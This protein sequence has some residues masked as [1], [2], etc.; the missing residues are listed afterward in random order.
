[1][2]KAVYPRFFN[3]EMSW[4]AFN[5]RVLE[6]GL[7]PKVP[8]LERLKFLAITASNLD[9]FCMVRVG[10]LKLLS[11][12]HVRCSDNTGLTPRQQLQRVVRRIRQ[13]MADQAALY[14]VLTAALE[15]H[16]LT[17]CE[18][19]SALSVEQRAWVLRE[20]EERVFPLLSPVALTLGRDYR[21]AGLLLHC[22][23]RL[24]ERH[25]EDE[26]CVA[27][28][29][30]GPNVPR[31]L[32]APGQSGAVFVP[33]ERVVAASAGRF[34]EGRKVLECV[35]FRVTRN[36][37]IELR[38]DLAPDLLVG[39]QE[40]LDERRETACVR[41]EIH[42]SASR[43]L[44]AYL[45]SYLGLDRTDLFPIDGP[46]DL[47]ALL[48]VVQAEGYETLRDESWR[49]V[50][51]PL[52][53]S[54]EPL[55]P[56]IA[57]RDIL[58]VHPYESFDPVVKFLEDAADDPDVMAIKQVLYR[59]ASGS[60]IVEALIRSAQAGKLVT[61][62]IELKARF[63][64][65]RNITQARRLEQAGVQVV[66]G[67]RGLKTHA[68]V[69]VV[70]RREP[71]GIVRYMHFGTGN[72]NERTATLYSDVGLFTCQ[73][74]LGADASDF[75]N[76]VTGYSQ[77][78]ALRRLEMSPFTLR[79]AL[80]QLISNE[81]AR[82]RNKEKALVM[83]KMNALTDEALIEALYAASKAGVKIRLNVRGICC[84]RPGVKGLSENISVVSIVDRFLE[85]ARIF[86]FLDGGQEK[87][88]IS[89][90]D[91]MLRNLDKRVEL[92]V[93]ILDLQAKR[94][95][96]KMLKIYFKDNVK[97]HMLCADGTYQRCRPAK[98]EPP[99]RSQRVLYEEAV[100]AVQ[101]VER[102][103]PTVLEPHRRRAAVK[104]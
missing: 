86:F 48:S 103:K 77:P 101:T 26:S 73:P 7:D 49:P 5:Q 21:P 33:V 4:L 14:R 55:F 82:A 54:K 22:A 85:H 63:D 19:M 12:G 68:K 16:G 58:L 29:P 79:T 41:L 37:D 31:Y 94:R 70:V 92:M 24:E 28:L 35:P 64:E 80:L 95:L 3:R 93:P 30:L 39:M 84:L 67:V 96:Q 45:A 89:S 6:E 57:E 47:R 102:M 42:R 36:A 75:F 72:Y 15:P 9:E 56:Q 38:E 53:E 51:S 10:G 13:M 27:I 52:V 78:Q 83:L 99:F 87:L 98:G 32:R 100:A 62:L 18:S 69:S 76:A 81:A 97:A 65:A 2:S 34:F 8:L 1:M 90:A 91:G 74:E 46:L 43:G 20:F 23:I 59:T 17:L 88:F 50:P 71:Q 44:S 40:L 61:V 11:E 25:A 60:R 66:Y 104:R